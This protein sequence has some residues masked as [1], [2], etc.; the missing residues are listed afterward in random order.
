M[1]FNG[2]LT[3]T[4][5]S[6]LLL[7]GVD[8]DDILDGCSDANLSIRNSRL[9]S[10]SIICSNMDIT[11]DGGDVFPTAATGEHSLHCGLSGDESTVSLGV[12]R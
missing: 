2:S 3:G 10:R 11:D 12:L 5:G 8:K 4:W 1:T 9:S 6:D 7:V